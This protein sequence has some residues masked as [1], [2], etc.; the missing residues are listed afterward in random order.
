L[1]QSMTG[2]ARGSVTTPQ[3]SVIVELRSVNN[4]YLD[5]YF[6]CP[7]NVRQW[8]PHWRQQISKAFSRGKIEA[9]IRVSDNDEQ[10]L[11]VNTEALNTL[12]QALDRVRTHL[13]D[14]PVPDQM[15]LLLAPGVL[16]TDAVSD[17]VL[18][19]ACNE[20]MSAAITELIA[21]RQSEGS[22]LRQLVLQ[23]VGDM[24]SR[25]GLL[26]EKLPQLRQQQRQRI[27]DKLSSAS[28]QADPLRLEEELV[29]VAQRADVDEEMDRLDAHLAAITAALEGREPCGRRLDFLMQELNREANTL[30]S[31][32]TAIDTTNTAVEF[33]VLI[34]QMREQIQNIE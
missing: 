11:T 9:T 7:E 27:L 3:C 32:S 22:A 19:S 16:K 21:Q 20:A 17:T 6:R 4:R 10:A 5:L 33:K 2:F 30:S 23:R 12:K 8:E 18:K 28:V 34:E 31:K 25:L 15:A 26:R 24:S 14:S 29:Y 1:T 13:P